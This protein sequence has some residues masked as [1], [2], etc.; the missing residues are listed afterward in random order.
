MLSVGDCVY[1][2]MGD[3]SSPYSVIREVGSLVKANLVAWDYRVCEG[4]D[5]VGHCFE[6][7]ERSSC[8][9]FKPILVVVLCAVYICLLCSYGGIKTVQS[10]SVHISILIV[11][12]YRKL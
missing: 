7:D 3:R 12:C 10:Y 1:K 2:K 5:F 8:G 4:F 9:D 11:C 6:S